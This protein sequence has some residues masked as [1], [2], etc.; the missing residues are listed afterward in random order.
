M[1]MRKVFYFNIS[2]DSRVK[3]VYLLNNIAVIAQKS[4]FL[5]QNF[6]RITAPLS[7]FTQVAFSQGI[8][9]WKIT[10]KLQLDQ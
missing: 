5:S 6:V 10:T 2:T 8:K 1:K 9:F 3:I 4:L 7:V